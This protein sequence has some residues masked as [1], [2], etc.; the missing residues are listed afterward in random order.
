MKNKI[1]KILQTGP[2]FLIL[3]VSMKLA[4]GYDVNSTRNASNHL[5]GFQFL[6]PDSIVISGNS[7]W[8]LIK[9][10]LHVKVYSKEI[11]CNDSANGI[12][13]KNVLLKIENFTGKTIKV[14]WTNKLFYDFNCLTCNSTSG[15]NDIEIIINPNTTDTGQCGS[16]QN[17]LVLFIEM[18]GI[19]S[20]KLTSFEL[21]NFS[22]MVK[23]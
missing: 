18:I 4:I 2:L 10:T 17:D 13:M 9:T 8:K 1:K 22:S 20:E 23:L 11:V 15:E 16:G 7:N 19:Q 6:N 5:S 21:L 14:N 12:Y 3:L